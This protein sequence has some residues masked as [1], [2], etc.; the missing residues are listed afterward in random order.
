MDA[1]LGRSLQIR[2]PSSITR[3]V[4]F[5]ILS[6]VLMMA[7]HQGIRLHQIRASL[8]IIVYPIQIVAGIPSSIGRW[9]SEAATGKDTLQHDYEELQKQNL[10]LQARLLK[11]DAL[12]AENNR[13]RFLLTSAERVADR[14]I[15]AE[16]LY[17]Q[18][19]PFTR[20]V[21]ISRGTADEIYVRQPV[22]D[23]H[24]IMGQV[25]S[26][27]IHT[28]VVTLITDPSHAV[29][30]YVNRNGLRTIAV[31][32]GAPDEINLPYLYN[33]ADIKEGDLLM[34]SGMGGTF[35][36]GYPV[37][38][39]TKIINDPNEPSLRISAKPMAKL[40]HNRELLLIWPGKQPI[41]LDNEIPANG[42]EHTK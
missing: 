7:D 2:K 20:S 26:T 10:S 9:I 40:D 37:A 1:S 36:A 28:S 34:T 31:G 5:V 13:F 39:V 27:G 15:V 23:A 18:P 6:V 14:V 24:G 25:T 32:T 29:P 35:P 21:T 38:T 30:V 12:V 16:L 42:T 17:V 11:Y 3:L 33:T 22:I 41:K 8:S 4:M 19:D